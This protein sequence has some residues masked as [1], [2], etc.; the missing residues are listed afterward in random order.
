MEMFKMWFSTD[1]TVTK[2]QVESVTATNDWL[3][4]TNVRV[5][6]NEAFN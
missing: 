6:N 1:F 5:G 3:F 2:V 4:D